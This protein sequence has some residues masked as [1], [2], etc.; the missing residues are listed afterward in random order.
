MVDTLF[1]GIV[2]AGKASDV[3]LTGW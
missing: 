1:R 2:T 3:W